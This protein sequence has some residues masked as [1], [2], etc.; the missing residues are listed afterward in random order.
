MNNSNQKSYSKNKYLFSENDIFFLIY[1]L[2]TIPMYYSATVYN[3]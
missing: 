2:K 3:K 1:A